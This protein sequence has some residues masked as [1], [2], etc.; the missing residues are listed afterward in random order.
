[1]CIPSDPMGLDLVRFW[2]GSLWFGVVLIWCDFGG[3]VCVFFKADFIK[4]DI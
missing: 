2:P 4:E 1:M 3:G